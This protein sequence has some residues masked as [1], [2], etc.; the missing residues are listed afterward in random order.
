MTKV[1]SLHQIVKTDICHLVICTKN[2][3]KATG[4]QVY[5]LQK[6]N[7]SC[8]QSEQPTPPTI[9][10]PNCKKLKNTKEN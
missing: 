5:F 3:C 1:N 8:F 4:I 10:G 7:H 9:P 6:Y 2:P